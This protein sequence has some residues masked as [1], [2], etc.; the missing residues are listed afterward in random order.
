MNGSLPRENE[1]PLPPLCRLAWIPGLGQAARSVPPLRRSAA[2]S[3]SSP[4]GGAGA[5]VLAA[6]CRGQRGAGSAFGGLHLT[7]LAIRTLAH[8]LET[9]RGN[10]MAS[11]CQSIDRKSTRLN[12]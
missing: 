12:S 3:P 7:L 6:L 1:A 11:A 5:S 4:R 10:H 8:S 9:V 2:G